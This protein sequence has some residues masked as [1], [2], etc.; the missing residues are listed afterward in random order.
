MRRAPKLK[1]SRARSLRGCFQ[2]WGFTVLTNEQILTKRATAAAVRN[3]INSLRR[4]GA[5][6]HYARIRR[7]EKYEQRLQFELGDYQ[8]DPTRL[9]GHG[10]N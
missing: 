3:E 1:K 5:L 4:R 2:K 8:V 6:T 7:L 10:G 9:W